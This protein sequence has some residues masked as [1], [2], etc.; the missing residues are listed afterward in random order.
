M[1]L[2]HSEDEDLKRK[3]TDAL[4][5]LRVTHTPAAIKERLD[6]GPRH[7][8]LR[9]F[10]YGAIDGT[11]T[12]FAI[13]SAVAG[14]GLSIGVVIILGIA[15]LVADGFSMAV[16]N[17]LGTRAEE[18][19]RQRARRTEEYH[20]GAFPEGERE[21]ILQIF[22]AKGFAGKNLEKIVDLIT[23]NMDHWVDT[24]LIEELGLRSGG[25]PAWRAACTTFIAFTL[26]GIFPLASFLVNAI[27]PGRLADP[28]FWS[29]LLTGMAFF[30]VGAL[31]SRFVDQR[32][33]VAGLETLLVGGAAATLAYFA[34]SLLKG[35]TGA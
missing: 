7:S 2:G 15:N 1:Y 3:H 30:A 8:Y 34:G 27:T 32:W 20:I 33:Y 28:F 35:V 29:A 4:A 17:F 26:V 23:S 24:M 10:I 21:E 31:K 11:V 18:Q 5:N 13:V 25:P 12:T 9:D 14:A 22:A 19:L 6:S 16:S